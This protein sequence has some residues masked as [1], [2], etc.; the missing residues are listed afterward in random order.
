MC[1]DCVIGVYYD[2]DDTR[3]ITILELKKEVESRQLA[4]P[5]GFDITGNKLTTLKQYFD[6][7]YNTNLSRFNYCPKCGNKIDWEKLRKEV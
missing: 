7:R 4:Y 1:K 2:Y 3:E 6:K 5:N